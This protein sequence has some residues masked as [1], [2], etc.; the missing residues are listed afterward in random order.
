[1]SSS[2]LK[3]RAPYSRAA[4]KQTKQSSNSRNVDVASSSRRARLS[5]RNT[6]MEHFQAI[7][8]KQADAELMLAESAKAQAEAAKMSALAI[9][10]MAQGFGKFA[11]A[12][13]AQVVNDRERTHV[14]EKLTNV[15]ENLLP[16]YINE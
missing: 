12:A 10:K 14:F 11:D 8:Q 6:S 13:A 4:P 9:S 3:N 7:A 5:Q 15:L 16:S 2:K 1:Q